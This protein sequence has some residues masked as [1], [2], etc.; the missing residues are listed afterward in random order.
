ML[1]YEMLGWSRDVGGGSYGI[2]WCFAIG[3]LYKGGSKTHGGEKRKEERIIRR[4][5]NPW[6]FLSFPQLFIVS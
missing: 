5:I 1:N 6:T 2:R 3:W 4:S